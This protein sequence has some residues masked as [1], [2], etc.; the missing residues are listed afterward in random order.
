M[1][2]MSYWTTKLTKIKFYFAT[3]K[4][5]HTHTEKHACTWTFIHFVF[6]TSIIK[7]PVCA[8]LYLH[9][10]YRTYHFFDDCILPWELLM[11][12]LKCLAVEQNIILCNQPLLS[13]SWELA[14]RKL[15]FFFFFQF[16]QNWR[17]TCVCVAIFQCFQD[18]SFLL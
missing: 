13:I 14:F 2:L 5:I 11:C 16:H 6:L 7:A 17:S 12:E 18:S 4:H 10:F 9:A 1:L 3:V 8:Y 15:L